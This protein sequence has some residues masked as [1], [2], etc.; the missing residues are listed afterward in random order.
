MTKG[1]F[2]RLSKEMRSKPKK[3]LLKKATPAKS[4][5]KPAEAKPKVAVNKGKS[6]VKRSQ[7]PPPKSPTRTIKKAVARKKPVKKVE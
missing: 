1:D 4:T 7:T 6:S 2:N 5:K 3:N